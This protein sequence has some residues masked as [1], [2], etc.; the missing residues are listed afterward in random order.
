[1]TKPTKWHV[2]PAETQISLGI[3]PVRSES[4]LCTQWVAKDPM[5]PHADSEVSLSDWADAQADLS[6]RWAY[7][8]F[9]WFCHVA[10]HIKT[11]PETISR[12]TTVILYISGASNISEGTP[13]APAE[14]TPAPRNREYEDLRRRIESFS[15]WPRNVTQT[16]RQLA[17]AGFFH[18]GDYQFSFCGYLN[19]CFWY[20]IKSAYIPNE[21]NQSHRHG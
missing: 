19:L 11:S 12:S 20:I 21:C 3:R 4:S 1:M 6:L 14:G 10:A 5:I 7:R 16:P 15:E 2:R 9:C 18:T 17:E 8:Q 13:I